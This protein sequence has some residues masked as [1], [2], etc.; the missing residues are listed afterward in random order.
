MKANLRWRRGLGGGRGRLSTGHGHG[1]V[2]RRED[3]GLDG[4]GADGVDRV[5]GGLGQRKAQEGEEEKELLEEHGVRASERESVTGLERMTGMRARAE[6]D[7][8]ERAKEARVVV[9]RL[10]WFCARKRSKALDRGC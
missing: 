7:D 5:V 10:L 3:V 8:A 1:G 9:G 6:R 2:R 4:D